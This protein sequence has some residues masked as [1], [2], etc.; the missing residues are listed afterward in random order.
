MAVK[1]SNTTGLW[2]AGGTWVGGVAPVDGDSFVIATGHTVTFDVD[3]SG[4]ATGMVAGTITGTLALTT[5][6][7]TYYLKMDGVSGHNIGGAGS[8]LFGSSGS[9]IANNVKCTVDLG[10]SSS[11]VGSSGMIADFYGTGPTNHYAKISST[12]A[13]GQTTLSIDRDLTGD[14]WP[15]SGANARVAIVR[16]ASGG[17]FAVDYRTVSAI[18]TGPNEIDITSGLSAQMETGSYVVLLYRNIWIKMPSSATTVYAL[19]AFTSTGGTSRIRLYDVAVYNDAAKGNGGAFDGNGGICDMV[20]GG[21][22]VIA[23]AQNGG[24]GNRVI[25]QDDVIS[26][27]IDRGY[28]ITTNPPSAGN[29][30]W[31]ILKD[32][33][34]YIGC[35]G[36]GASQGNGSRMSVIQDSWIISARTALQAG[37]VRV[38]G[39]VVFTNCRELT[40]SGT[41]VILEKGV[42]FINSGQLIRAHGSVELYGAI[43]GGSGAE[44][45]TQDVACTNN[46]N[47]KAYG[48]EFRT[49]TPVTNYLQRLGNPIGYG[50]EF[51]NLCIYDVGDGSG[52]PQPGR[53]KA[54]YSGGTIDYVLTAS[55]PASPPSDPT[56]FH[57]FNYADSQYYAFVDFPIYAQRNIPV[58]IT[59]WMVNS[60]SGSYTQLPKVELRDPSYGPHDSAGAITSATMAD[61]TSWQTLTLNHTPTTD[62]QLV[63]RV[64]GARASGITYFNY[65]VRQAPGLLGISSMNGGLNG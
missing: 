55:A 29:A 46:I 53:V 40:D 25:V 33:G 31:C 54:W 11:I 18:R 59:T 7:G 3:Q 51:K 38:K 32:R 21:K 1:T 12:E 4:F 35:S 64:Y 26:V 20:I 52:N 14:I 28:S 41:L 2:S 63:L 62:R 49:S 16:I 22:T 24:N 39:S 9:P 50:S 44:A 45:N 48:A 30:W 27:D 57:R 37:A 13:A 8:F 19:S 56:F 17:N 43:I 36:G 23:K 42:K 15:T 6:A 47:I 10:A 34:I 61:N 60:V 5:T 58:T 65:Q